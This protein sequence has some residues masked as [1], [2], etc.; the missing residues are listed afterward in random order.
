MSILFFLAF[1]DPL[2]NFLSH[3]IFFEVNPISLLHWPTERSYTGQPS[4]EFHLLGSQ[5]L[6]TGMVDRAIQA[7]ARAAR[8]GEFTP[9]FRQEWATLLDQHREALARYCRL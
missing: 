1:A 4:A 8:P 3:W 6:L 7:G 2:K 5:P 9:W